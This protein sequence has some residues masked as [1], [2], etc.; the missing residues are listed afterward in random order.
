MLVDIESDLCGRLH[1]RAYLVADKYLSHIALARTYPSML[2]YNRGRR[3]F[4]ACGCRIANTGLESS[5]SAYLLGFSHINGTHPQLRLP[6]LPF[7]NPPTTNTYTKNAHLR[8][9]SSLPS[10]HGRQR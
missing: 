8:R 4:V 6:A 2:R 3:C 7:E 9:S 1:G 5:A 10:P